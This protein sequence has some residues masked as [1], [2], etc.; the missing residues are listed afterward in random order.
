MANVVVISDASTF[1]LEFN[2][3]APLPNINTDKITYSRKAIV[4]VQKK[5]GA[6]NLDIILSI[7]V[8][9]SEWTVSLDLQPE[10]LQ[11][12]TIN[13]TTPADIDDLYSLIVGLMV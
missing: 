12:D 1:T 5:H 9:K 13:G 2:D 8:I 4:Q 10:S 7:G 11:I 3:L 6:N